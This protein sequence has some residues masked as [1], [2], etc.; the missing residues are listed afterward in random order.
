M[1]ERVARH[2]A[3]VA[4]SVN[5]D[6]RPIHV[7]LLFQP[8]HAVLDI[9][10]FELTE[11]LVHRPHRFAAFAARRPVVADPDDDPVLRQELVIHVLRTAPRVAH[12]LRVRTA[13]RELID[14]VPA[15]WVEAG[16]L[17][18][19]GFHHEAVARL[20]LE[21]LRCGQLVIV[22]CPS[23]LRVDDARLGAVRSMQCDPIGVGRIAPRIQ[24]ERRGRIEARFMGARIG[25]NLLKSG[26]VELHAKDVAIARAPL[27]S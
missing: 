18:H 19:H 17:D 11:I 16:R 21:K 26:A 14:R 13:V 5:P 2:V 3:A 23:R 24:V 10:Q 15:R 6:P 1:G 20:H 4:P 22:E 7:R 12:L 8:A 27:R 25:R 9:A